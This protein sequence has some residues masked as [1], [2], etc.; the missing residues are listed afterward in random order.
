MTRF[1]KL[2]A[3]GALAA[4]VLTGGVTL[5]TAQTVGGDK[6]CSYQLVTTY[7]F[8]GSYVVAVT[9]LEQTCVTVLDS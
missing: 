9:Q 6:E 1:H 8:Y 4:A 7:T 3:A 2:V 5:A